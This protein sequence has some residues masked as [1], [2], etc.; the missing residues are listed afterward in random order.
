V[1]CQKHFDDVMR[2]GLQH[3]LTTLV[4]RAFFDGQF[5]DDPEERGAADAFLTRVLPGERSEV[6][7]AGADARKL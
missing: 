4:V 7:Y 3:Q 6:S 5:A 2:V 1:P